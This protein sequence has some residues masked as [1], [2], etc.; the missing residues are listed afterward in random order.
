MLDRRDYWM[1]DCGD[2]DEVDGADNYM[3]RYHWTSLKGLLDK[4]YGR[5]LNVS[6]MQ[7]RGGNSID[8]PFNEFERGLLDVWANYR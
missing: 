7:T 3:E 5:L 8:Y 2:V 4:E 1:F 6:Q